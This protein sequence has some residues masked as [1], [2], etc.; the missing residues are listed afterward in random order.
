MTTAQ[1]DEKFDS[2]VRA[3]SFEVI[4]WD[5]RRFLFVS[6]ILVGFY[7][8]EATQ[9]IIEAKLYKIY[10]KYGSKCFSCL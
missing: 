2:V 6:L 8:I 1:T 5:D 3:E 9:T 10:I 4:Q 7:V